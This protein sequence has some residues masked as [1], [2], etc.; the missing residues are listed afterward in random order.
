MGGRM[1]IST[2]W[3]ILVSVTII[4]VGIWDSSTGLHPFDFS[5]RPDKNKILEKNSEV[6]PPPG[7][8][9]KEKNA[10][11]KMTYVAGIRK[12]SSEMSVDDA[13]EYFR[14]FGVQE[15]WI[16]VSDRKSAGRRVISFCVSNYNHSIEIAPRPEGSRL[17][18]ATYWSLD[19]DSEK[20]C[21]K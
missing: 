15:D 19:S 9:L 20:F 5:D 13:S 17:R 3:L 6:K 14:K 7:V 12:F 4:L 10:F 21:R 16:M 8:I 11:S 18:I 2:R 1:V